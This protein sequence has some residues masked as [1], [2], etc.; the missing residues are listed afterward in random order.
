MSPAI[1]TFIETPVRARIRIGLAPVQNA[2]HSLLLLTQRAHLS[3]LG[4]WVIE[5]D[6]N[7]SSEDRK[8]HYSVMIGF[9]HAIMPEKSWNNFQSYIDHLTAISPDELRDKMLKRYLDMPV[10]GEISKDFNMNEVIESEDKYIEFL[11]EKFPK[12]KIDEDLERWAYGYVIDPP[13]MKE[14]IVNHLQY[15]WDEFL[16]DEW[17]RVLPT[18]EKAVNAFK[19]IDFSQMDN[20]EAAK[21]IVGDALDKDVWEK[22]CRE[23]EGLYFAPSLHVGPYLGKFYLD[24]YQG[25][26]FGARLPDN[27][28]VNAPELNQADIYVRLNALADE[29]RLQILK[30]ISSNGESCSMEIIEALG[31]SQSAASRHLAQLTAT[32]YLVARRNNG[33]KCYHLDK[34]RII[35]TLDT[36]KEF[37]TA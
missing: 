11:K 22:K 28:N 3:G 14:L 17:N 7:L 6:K 1:Q 2:I 36:I 25:F 27:T 35:D 8:L 15:Y 34:K 5:T 13:A 26:I 4:G 10:R 21:F 24:N 31:L 12:S 9:Y 30:F 23:S 19:D 32:G 18:L 20:F 29:I 16:S 37:L 33:A